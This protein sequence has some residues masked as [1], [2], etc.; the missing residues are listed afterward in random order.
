[1]PI[2]LVLIGVIGLGVF[3]GYPQYQLMQLENE[4]R[5]LSLKSKHVFFSELV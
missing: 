3:W 5:K 4:M 1:M 2:I